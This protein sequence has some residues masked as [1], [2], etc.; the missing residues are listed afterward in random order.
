MLGF[1]LVGRM[2]LS[3]FGSCLDVDDGEVNVL[4]LWWKRK[5]WGDE[6]EVVLD[7]S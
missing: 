4:M 2:F 7:E 3:S 5:R 1:V 6:D